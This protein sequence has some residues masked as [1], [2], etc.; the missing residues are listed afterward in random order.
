MHTAA[1]A[2]LSVT[3]KV[4]AQRIGR[5]QSPAH[6]GL[7]TS[8]PN[9]HTQLGSAVL[10]ISTLVIHVITSLLIGPW[11][12][13]AIGTNSPCDESSAYLTILLD[14]ANSAAAPASRDEASRYD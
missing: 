2:A 7:W 5:R 14:A 11:D 3:D 1:A 13:T 6:T 9:S 10:M 12:S 4:G 8:R